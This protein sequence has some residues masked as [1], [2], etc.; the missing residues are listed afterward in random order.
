ML[1]RYGKWLDTNTVYPIDAERY[2]VVFDWYVED[3]LERIREESNANWTKAIK[4]NTRMSSDAD[5]FRKECIQRSL[6]MDV[7]R[8]MAITIFAICC[9]RTLTFDY[10]NAG[11]AT[12][13]P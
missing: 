11:T 2:K 1:N 5:A 4:C 8:Q 7:M 3:A 6:R 10:P 9:R 13:D 12:L